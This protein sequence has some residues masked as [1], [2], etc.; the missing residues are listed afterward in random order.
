MNQSDIFPQTQHYDLIQFK[1]LQV[2]T[3]KKKKELFQMLHNRK[4]LT[5]NESE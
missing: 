5:F 2:L 3:E 4:F 1:Q